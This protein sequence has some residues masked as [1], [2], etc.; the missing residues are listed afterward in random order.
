M[1]GDSSGAQRHL[2]TVVHNAVDAIVTIDE[3]GVILSANPATQRLFG[4]ELGELIGQNV[5]RLMPQPDRDRHDQYLRQYLATGQ[6]T[7]IGIGR[8]VTGQRK[9]GSVFPIHLAVS[10]SV[11]GGRRLWTGVVRDLSA[12]REA[13]AEQVSLGRIVEESLNEVFLFDAQSLRFVRVNRG[14]REN[15]GYS[16]AELAQMTPL[17]INPDLTRARYT[18]L[19]NLL[20]ASAEEK[21]TFETRHRRKDGS[22]YDAEVHLQMA[23]IQS[24]PVFVAIALDI[25]E[26][27]VAKR[28]L[29]QMNTE[30][31]QRVRERT[32]ALQAAQDEL[33]RR[34]RLVML[35]EVAGGISHEVR[36]PLNAITTSV[37]YLKHAEGATAEKI[38]EHLDRILIAK[39][40]LSTTW[41]PRYRT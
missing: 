30:L 35:G 2:E 39:W 29:A 17:D 37:Y 26:R 4:Y 28:E 34:E 11:F 36:N 40:R 21:V 12:L 27:N 19:L 10:E 3:T 22:S 15:L 9:D 25:T 20:Q 24:S 5:S 14:A 8:E 1:A 41:S 6:H 33:V 31:E 13:E 32:E 23:E 7:V 18:E 38:D 16:M